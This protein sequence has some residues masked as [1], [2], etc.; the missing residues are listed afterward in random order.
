MSGELISLEKDSYAIM[1]QP[2]APAYYEYVGI[3]E[4]YIRESLNENFGS[5]FEI[6]II[7]DTLQGRVCAL[8]T[9]ENVTLKK[10]FGLKGAYK[11]VRDDIDRFMQDVPS[12]WNKLISE[13]CIR[14]EK[15]YTQCR[16][17]NPYFVPAKS[18]MEFHAQRLEERR[19][20]IDEQR[21]LERDGSP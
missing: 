2:S 14:R 12:L 7:F 18:F 4:E 9:K 11:G 20:A 1:T 19:K 5:F 6:D 17:I 16:L 13:H 15:I 10:F 21:K 3:F 8:M